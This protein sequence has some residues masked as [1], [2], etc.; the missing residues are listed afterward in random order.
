MTNVFFLG[1]E[2]VTRRD[3][4]HINRCAFRQAGGAPNVLVLPWAR[5]APKGVSRRRVLL[6][7]YFRELGAKSVVFAELS[8]SLGNIAEQVRRADLVYLPGG[9]TSMLIKRLKTKGVD[10]LLHTYDRVIVGRSAGAL[11][12]CDAG[13]LTKKQPE[14]SLSLITGIGLVGLTLKVHYTPLV[15]HALE[16]LSYGRTVYAVPER[17]ALVYDGCSLS[18]I[19]NA[20]LFKGG[21]KR[22]VEFSQRLN[23]LKPWS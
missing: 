9:F 1:G 11:A 13:V 18:V 15:D 10:A 12:L 23:S 16:L 22:A 6:S 21:T 5:K 19:G 17:S 8:D 7:K 2:H 3:S 14:A 20:F 4:E